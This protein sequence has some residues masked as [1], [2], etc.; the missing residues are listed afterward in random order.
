MIANSLKVSKAPGPDGIPSLAIRLAIKMAPGLFRAVMQ[1]CLD[2]CLLPDRWKL[3][4]LILLPKAGKLPGDPAAYRP[5][6][7]LDTA[8]KVLER[9]ILN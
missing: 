5:I 1:R 9:I 7:L 2:D 6:C 4:S 3:Q 8:G